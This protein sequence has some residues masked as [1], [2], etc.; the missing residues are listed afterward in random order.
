MKLLRIFWSIVLVMSFMTI[1]ATERTKQNFNGGWRLAVGDFTEAAKP[2]FD[3]HRWQQVTLPYAFNGDEAFRKDIVDLTDT[4][5]WYRKAWSVEHGA[6]KD[7]KVFI[8]FEGVRQ[9]ADF[10]LNGQNLGYSENGV[11]ACGFDLTPYLSLKMCICTSPI[12]SIKPSHSIVIW[13]QRALISMPRILIYPII[14]P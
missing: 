1:G 8:E 11:M 4:I 6:L 7:K 2:D 12:S 10:Y 14:K 9:G 13:E 3:D 5:V